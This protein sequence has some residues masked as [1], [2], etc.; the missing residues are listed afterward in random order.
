MPELVR[1]D[2]GPDHLDQAVGDVQY[3]HADHAALRVVDDRARLA[4]DPGQLAACA[5]LLTAAV[6]PEQESG[7]PVRSGQRGEQRLPL[8]AAV[9]DHDDVG[10]EQIEQAGQVAAARGGE[11]P[12]GHLVALRGRCLEA[13]LAGAGPALVDVAPGP[14]EDLA[15]VRLGLAGDLGDLLVVVA[16]HLV[17][18]EHRALGRRQALK[19]HEE[20]HRQRIGHLGPLRGVGLAVRDERLG[21][22]G[23]DVGLTAH[24]RGPQVADRQPGGGRRQERLGQGDGRAVAKRAG[25]PEEGLLHDVLG[26]A[27]AAG[28]PVCDRE[29]QRPVLGEVVRVH[30]ALLGIFDP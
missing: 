22:P 30:A 5:Q 26:V 23:A 17:Q 14:D 12:A 16:E 3:E 18:Q 19:Q 15:A 11:E 6:Q 24:P 1:V 13:W 20:R 25:Q 8:A 29:H 4:V 28:H 2:D 21:Q 9:A 10:R 7:D 27:D